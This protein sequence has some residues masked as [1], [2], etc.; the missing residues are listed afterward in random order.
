MPRSG[1]A[2][3]QAQQADVIRGAGPT[4]MRE[5]NMPDAASKPASA[6]VQGRSSATA[7]GVE[8]VVLP[9]ARASLPVVT[10]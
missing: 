1:R 9:V 3:E 2:A 4:S 5:P 8:R 7:W 10:D 6:S